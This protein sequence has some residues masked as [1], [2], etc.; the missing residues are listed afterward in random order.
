MG[1]NV[2]FNNK[3][4]N[5]EDPKSVSQNP[6]TSTEIPL[7]Q[8][9]HN[10]KAVGAPVKP[11]DPGKPPGGPPPPGRGFPGGLVVKIIIGIVGIA[12]IAFLIFG[13]AMPFFSQSSDSEEKA[14]LTYWGLW[15]NE[16]TMNVI[17]DEF[18]KD[19]PNITVNYVKQD[20]VKYS[21]KLKAQLGTE[22]GP[23]IF[24]FHNTWVPL[25]K[26]DLLPLPQEVISAENC[27]TA[28]Y[29]VIVDDLAQT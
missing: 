2:I 8:L 21:E 7:N 28:Y 29:P 18:E 13:V 10:L 5:G 20:P 11:S 1:D 15:E 12:V 26:S 9:P 4:P 3:G 6:I 17:I 22:T 19:H 24:R 16:N 27:K 23:D 25:F 14:S